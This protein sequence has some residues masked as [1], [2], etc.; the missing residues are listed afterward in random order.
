MTRAGTALQLGS[1]MRIQTAQWQCGSG[2]G[3]AQSD[4]HT[5]CKGVEKGRVLFQLLPKLSEVNLCVPQRL[6]RLGRS[7]KLLACT[8]ARDIGQPS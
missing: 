1:Q 7:C 5:C 4:V 8:S 6:F 2:S 3:S